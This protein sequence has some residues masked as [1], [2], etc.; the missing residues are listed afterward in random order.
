MNAAFNRGKDGF[1]EL[2]GFRQFPERM[3]ALKQ[4]DAT[5][6]HEEKQDKTAF[7]PFSTFPQTFL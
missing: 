6:N 7:P 2:N 3:Q 1:T 5:F 4:R